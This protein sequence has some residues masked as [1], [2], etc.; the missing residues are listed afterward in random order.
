M[1]GKL[2]ATK[3]FIKSSTVKRLDSTFTIPNRNEELR[4]MMVLLHHPTTVY[5][6]LWRSYLR[7]TPSTTKC[8]SVAMPIMW[9]YIWLG[10]CG[11]ADCSCREVHQ[12]LH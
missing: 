3:R 4:K 6:F 1:D 8:A 10:E 9:L 7:T 12:S 11:K 5:M 2:T